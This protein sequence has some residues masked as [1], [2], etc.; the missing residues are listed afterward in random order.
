[1]PTQVHNNTRSA[2]QGARHLSGVERNLELA[3]TA[4]IIPELE[5]DILRQAEALDA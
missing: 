5:M 4:H 1:M 3:L 2:D